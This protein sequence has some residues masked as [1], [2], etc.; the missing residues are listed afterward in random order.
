MGEG[1]LI[2]TENIIYTVQDKISLQA[3]HV[4]QGLAVPLTFSLCMLA[5]VFVF[6]QNKLKK[7]L[8]A[9]DKASERIANN[10]LDFTINYEGLDEMGRLCASFEKM[11]FSLQQ[12]NR[13]MWRQIEQ[14][15]RLNAAFAHDLRTPLTVLKG[16]SEI[17]QFPND[18]LAVKETALTMSKHINRLERYVDSMS[19]LQRMEDIVPDVRKVEIDKFAEHAEQMVGMICQ[20]SRKQCN[21]HSYIQSKK[22][23]LDSEMFSQVM[24]NL[25]SNAA[26]HAKSSVEVTL[27]EIDDMLSITVADDGAGFSADSLANAAEPYYTE[28]SDK[29]NH[30]GLGL[31]ICKILCERHNGSLKISNTDKGGKVIAFFKKEKIQ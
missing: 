21:F 8:T 3:I 14:R 28:S 22:A 23:L 27:S 20:K 11:R 31:Y 1:S 6:Y 9:L 4:I 2:G 19:T 26:Y 25:V 5:A 24:E 17:L 30:F 10:D 29:S 15:K 7:P 16:Y 18:G 12:N 13:L